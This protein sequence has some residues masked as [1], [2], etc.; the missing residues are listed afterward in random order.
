MFIEVSSGEAF[1]KLT[2]L[3]IKSNRI[4]SQEKREAVE[5]EILALS[6]VIRIKERYPFEYAF[7]MFVNEEIWDLTEIFCSSRVEVSLRVFDLNQKR[8]RVKRL[9]NNLESS[10]V[11]E[12]K[13]TGEKHCVIVADV[14]PRSRMVELASILFDYDT[15]SFSEPCDFVPF[16]VF[17]NNKPP[18][19][20][21]IL[22]SSLTVSQ[23]FLDRVGKFLR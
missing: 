8:F 14:D 15:F 16:S 20:S 6:E 3:E 13:S 7:L 4:Q 9:I 18:V 23:T 22:L 5:K 12:Q 1:D 17:I 19:Y 2:I 21:E 11:K 10:N